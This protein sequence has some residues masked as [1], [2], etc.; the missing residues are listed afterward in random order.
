VSGCSVD[1]SAGA[2]GPVCSVVWVDP[3]GSRKPL[4]CSVEAIVVAIL[5]LVECSAGVVW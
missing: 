4:R 2:S 1:A 5:T 3:Q